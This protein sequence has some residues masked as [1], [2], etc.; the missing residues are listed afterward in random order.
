LKKALGYTLI[1]GLAEMLMLGLLYG[2]TLQP[3][4]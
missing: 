1:T 2:L 4:M 3:A